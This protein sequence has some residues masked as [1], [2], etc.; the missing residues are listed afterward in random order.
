MKKF[1]WIFWAGMVLMCLSGC[2][3]ENVVSTVSKAPVN[4]NNSVEE[5]TAEAVTKE[6]SEKNMTSND[7]I[8][9]KVA[10]EETTAS[11]SKL[12]EHDIVLGTIKLTLPKSWRKDVSYKVTY[13]EE[14]TTSMV[15]FYEEPDRSE[16]GTGW[17]CT[18]IQSEGNDPDDY[19]YLPSFDYLGEVR[20][21]D[22]TKYGIIVEYPTD[23]QPSNERRDLYVKLSE[24]IEHLLASMEPID[25]AEFYENEGGISEYI[26][27]FSD[28]FE[29]YDYDL[30]GLTK[31]ELRIA[32][33]E[34]YAR[35]GRLFHD[36]KLQEYFDSCSWY[37][38]SIEPEKFDDTVLS[39]IE[40]RNL[41]MIISYE[42]NAAIS[43]TGAGRYDAYWE[44]MQ[45]SI[46][47]D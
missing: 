30:F 21:P 47:R 38:G 27:P 36:T 44:T 35:H 18:V 37:A 17:L 32:R 46:T 10:T 28:M 9:M 5:T 29:L 11:E 45:D 4:K 39:D 7:E 20:C 41:E 15:H 40:R 8:G 6:K 16:F 3:K 19:Y 22:G 2:Q 34:I 23:V 1:K 12:S 24:D 26:F 13:E 31:E 33:N 42:N 25:A 14:N 43:P